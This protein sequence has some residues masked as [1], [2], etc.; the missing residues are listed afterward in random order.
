MLRRPIAHA[1]AVTATLAA[2]DL[3][4]IALFGSE[5]M[6]TLPLLLYTRLGSH[7]LDEAAVTAMLLVCT[8]LVLY[9]V[10]VRSISGPV[11]TDS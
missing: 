10:I 6:Q 1:A 9:S 7:R 4:A 8:C 5:R 2:G 11:A 3:G